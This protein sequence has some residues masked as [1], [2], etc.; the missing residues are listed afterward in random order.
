MRDLSRI[1]HML[2]H[3]S[4]PRRIDPRASIS[5]AEVRH[6]RWLTS[7]LALCV[8]LTAAAPALARDAPT[9]ELDPVH[10]RVMFAV[11]HAGFSQALGT[12]SGSTGTLTF[13]PDDWQQTRLDATVP[14]ERVDLGDPSWN[15]ATLAQR[16]LDAQ[17]HPLA[18]FTSQSAI[19]TGDGK[20]RVC[21]ELTLH[22]V[23]RPLCMDVTVNAIKRHPMP[24]FRRTAGFSA[25]AMLSRSDFG[26]TAWPSVIGDE[27]TIRI[28]AE[29]V[30][31]RSA[32]AEPEFEAEAEAE[33]ET[34]SKPE[35]EP[36]ALQ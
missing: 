30:R 21:G 2:V 33:A 28:E 19:P 1:G 23:T 35:L 32:P 18:R 4:K 36:G 10:T 22:G 34:K 8:A 6:P 27:V 15:R 24:P 16:L 14:L 7:A 5:G 26:I 31:S 3:P 12:V 11:S 20:A 29:A 9:W 17:A 25:T 13:D